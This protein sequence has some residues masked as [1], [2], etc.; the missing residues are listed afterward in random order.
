MATAMAVTASVS[1]AGPDGDTD[2]GV[3][4]SSTAGD[5]RGSG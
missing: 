1:A 4:V 3:P 5:W 2:Y